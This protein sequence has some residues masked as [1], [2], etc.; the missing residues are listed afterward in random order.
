MKIAVLGST[1]YLGERIV[2]RL[3]AENAHEICCVHRETSD[4]SKYADVKNQLIF[5]KSDY[6]SLKEYLCEG[7]SVDCIINASCSY[8][9]GATPEQITESNLIFPLRA[10]NQALENLNREEPLRYIS[11]GTGLPKDFNIYTFAK[12]E[13]NRFGRFYAE[14]RKVQFVNVELQNYYGPFEPQERF[15]PNCIQKLKRN[16]P[17]PLTNGEQLRDFVH[18]EDVLDAVLLI[19]HHGELP[20]YLDIPIGTGES[21]S[22]R[23]ILY[24][25]KEIT[26]SQS[27][28]QFGAIPSRPNE[29]SIWADLSIYHMLGGNIRY[30]WKQGLIHLLEE[31]KNENS[32]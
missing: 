20:G 14:Q 18:V 11:M 17:I 22:I 29:P 30:P 24:F 2:R 4:L 27:E 8:M 25:L 13:L 32:H 26:H 1:G 12:N 6:R 5:C 9:R 21:P 7:A 23:E 10:L 28:L 19:L 3:L 16:E 15:L 31:E